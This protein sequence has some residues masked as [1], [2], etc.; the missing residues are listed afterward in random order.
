MRDL[1]KTRGAGPQ[2]KPGLPEGGQREARGQGNVGVR[3]R[4][5]VQVGARFESGIRTQLPESG[6]RAPQRAALCTR[7]LTTAPPLPRPRRPRGRACLAVRRGKRKA[8]A[9]SRWGV[10]GLCAH[11]HRPT[12]GL[13]SPGFVV[14]SRRSRRSR[15]AMGSGPVAGS[16][17]ARYLVF[18]QYVGTDFKYVPTSRAPAPGEARELVPK[19]SEREEGAGAVGFALPAP[20]APARS[21]RPPTCP[22]LPTAGARLSG[23]PSARSGCRTTWR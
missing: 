13:H 8:Q 9:R 6:P 7:S 20:P 3:A 11:A 5:G 18:F 16:V 14:R 19:G 15:R 17:R 2:R 12:C 10:A 1:C 4:G 23:A 21:G 22:P